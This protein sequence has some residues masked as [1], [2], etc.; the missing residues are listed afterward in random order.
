MLYETHGNTKQRNKNIANTPCPE[1]DLDEAIVTWQLYNSSPRGTFQHSRIPGLQNLNNSLCCSDWPPASKLIE[2]ELT[3][4]APC[5]PCNLAHKIHLNPVVLDKKRQKPGNLANR[6]PKYRFLCSGHFIQVARS[7]LQESGRVA[8]AGTP[9]GS[10][11]INPYME[12]ASQ[13]TKIYQDYWTWSQNLDLY[14]WCQKQSLPSCWFSFNGRK[15]VSCVLVNCA[16]HL[17]KD[18]WP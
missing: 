3:C 5:N 15:H 17:G 10:W 13:R 9:D 11:R 16:A 8:S 14:P 6:F 7:N 4:S 1:G 12:Q 2:R 18:K